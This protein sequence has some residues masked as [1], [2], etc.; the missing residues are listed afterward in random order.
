MDIDDLNT[1]NAKRRKICGHRPEIPLRE[2]HIHLGG[3]L[4]ESIPVIGKGFFNNGIDLFEIELFIGAREI[5]HNR[6]SI[7]IKFEDM[8]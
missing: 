6:L 5:F 7:F 2:R 4:D 3:H 1:G 8:P